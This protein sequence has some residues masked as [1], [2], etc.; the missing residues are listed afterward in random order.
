MTNSQAR[1]LASAIA[2]LA[3]AVIAQTDNVNVN[4][5]LIVILLSSAMLIGEWFRSFRS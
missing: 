5:S 1:L 4:L 2:L 3:G